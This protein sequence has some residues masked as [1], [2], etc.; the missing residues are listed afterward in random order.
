MASTIFSVDS[1]SVL[2]SVS[3]RF[4]S[5]TSLTSRADQPR[6]VVNGSAA[7]G[8]MKTT[9][10]TTTGPSRKTKRTSSPQPAFTLPK[11]TGQLLVG[12][13]DSWDDSNVT[14]FRFVQSGHRWIR[15][16][17]AGSATTGP[18]RSGISGRLGPRGLSWGR[19]IHP[20]PVPKPGKEN[21]PGWRRK[22]EGDRRS[23][24]GVFRFG[25]AFGYDP[26]FSNRTKLPYVAVTERDLF[27]E[28]PTSALYNQHVRLDAAPAT[29]WERTQQMEQKAPAHRLEVFIEHNTSP[30]EPGAGSG[31]FLH[32]WRA[33]GARATS[34]CT[35]VDDASVE[36]LLGWLDPAKNPLYVLLP[37]SE[38]L[39]RQT[40]WGLPELPAPSNPAAANSTQRDP[41]PVVA[42]TDS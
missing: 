41:V 17:E 26:A 15:V 28:D 23:P 2:S 11:R 25:Q 35:S 8:T 9:S 42:Q 18:D 24:A 3:L 16:R 7:T 31:I 40:A 36:S 38:Y 21:E 13:T 19:G 29:D 6:T 5:P 27:I 10:K 14:L 39:A 1:S 22:V 37:R 32:I 20:N 30:V 12:V 34:G 33:K 4:S